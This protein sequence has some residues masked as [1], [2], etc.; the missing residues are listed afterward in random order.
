MLPRSAVPTE[1]SWCEGGGGG[2]GGGSDTEPCAPKTTIR[3]KVRWRQQKMSPRLI[4][5][6]ALT[7]GEPPGEKPWLE[8][9]EVGDWLAE[10]P[11]LWRYCCREAAWHE[12]TYPCYSDRSAVLLKSVDSLCADPFILYMKLYW[13][14]C[15]DSFSFVTQDESI[16]PHLCP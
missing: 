12:T 15:F 11:T 7:W 5:S 9:G 3:C 10:D 8:T 2:S 13:R 1:T 14:H 16:L 6:H 4:G